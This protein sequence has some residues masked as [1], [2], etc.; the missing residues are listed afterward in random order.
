V[1]QSADTIVVLA[2]EPRPGLVKTRLQTAFTAAEAA[3]L[4][5]AA[6][7]DTLAA[8]RATGLRRL[9]A[10][11]GSP[12]PW[13]AGWPVAAQPAGDL[14]ARLTAAFTA[15]FADP[16]AGAVLLIGMDTP[17]VTPAELTAD[18]RGADAVL[19]LSEDGGFWAIGL[20][21][22]HP[23]AV[24][25]GIPDVDRSHRR[26]PAGPALRARTDRHPARPVA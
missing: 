12:T 17:Q 3:D 5:A 18:W 6:I 13:M 19:G 25:D 10:L 11:D 24:F 20:R 16:A 22:G 15:A 23:A 9:L 26:R 2:K 4:A 1:K 21:A 14:N 7:A 8:A